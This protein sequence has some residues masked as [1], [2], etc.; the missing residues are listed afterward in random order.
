MKKLLFFFLALAAGC[1]G[2]GQTIDRAR[3]DS[4]FNVGRGR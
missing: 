4:L 3:L 2:F 1:A